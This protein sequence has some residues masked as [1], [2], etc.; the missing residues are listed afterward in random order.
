[1][2]T[3]TAP[4]R[5]ATGP[6]SAPGDRDPSATPAFSGRTPSKTSAIRAGLVLGTA[7]VVVIG[8]AVAMG[9]GPRTTSTAGANPGVAAASGSPGPGGEK[10][11]RNGHGF[12]HGVFGPFGGLGPIIGFGGGGPGKG[13][14]RGAGGVT[15][16][17]IDGSSVSLATVDGWTRTIQ[18]TSTTTITR[19]GAPATAADLH[20]GD[21]I[22]FRQRR[23][24]DG[25]FT[26]TAVD[27]VLPTVIGTI[28]STSDGTITITDRD[29]A[30]VTIHIAPTTK[31]RVQGK[32]NATAQDLAK[33]LVVIVAGD[34][35]GDG[36][37]D[38]SGILA[39][40]LGDFR[41]EH[42][43]RDRPGPSGA[44]SASSAPG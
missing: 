44:P 6:R 8:S 11:P 31:I 4:A 38:A 7:L 40:K 22:R 33:G 15:I 43:K 32:E 39:G 21:A 34:R 42:Q 16:T 29:G 30:T 10:G 17:A 23:S 27:V 26:I 5:D 28:Q 14:G 25:T 41:R 3:S 37:I 2:E 20:V 19:G 9:A 35:R 36:S 13:F 18:L 12:G 1:M 24:D